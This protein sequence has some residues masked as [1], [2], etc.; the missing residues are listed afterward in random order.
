M[1]FDPLD[2]HRRAV[3][4][5]SHED[6]EP[7]RTLLVETLRDAGA[8]PRVDEHG[9]VHAVRGAGD[10]H[11]VLN[12]HID[13][14]A[15]HVP[16]EREGETAYGRG[17][18]DAKGPLAALVA[19]FLRAD[20]DGKLTLAVTPDEE[21]AQTGAVAVAGTFDADG[22]VVGEPTGLDVCTAA[23]GMFSGTVALRGEAG[24]AADPANGVNAVRAAGPVL[25]AMDTYDEE[26]GP[27]PDP[28]L[29]A[30]T[31]T[32]TRITGGEALNQIP[33]ACEI[34]FDRR[35]VPPE[36]AAEFPASLEAHL[37]AACP[38]DVD[39]NVSL[40]GDPEQFDDPF[41]TDSDEPLV[42]ALADAS[43]GEVRAFGAATEASHFAPHAPTVVFGP[44]DLSVAHSADERVELPDVE[45]AAAA[46]TAAVEELL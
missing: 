28:T 1:S 24:H 12:T 30:P 16:Y 38:D 43:G 13:T 23:R 34:T 32:P 36:T 6:V 15:P 31:L 44:G 45:R 25:Q 5:P 9:V 42:Q 19:A 10:P 4:T 18:C 33:A 11:L 2:F 29:G 20:V 8:D 14:V 39:L 21:T 22:Y 7:M 17:A 37:R 46:V 40:T 3:E 26:R 27:D 35:S 41:V